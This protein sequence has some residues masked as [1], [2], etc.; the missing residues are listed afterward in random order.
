MS[1]RPAPERAGDVVPDGME[2]AGWPHHGVLGGRIRVGPVVVA[3]ERADA[4]AAE[5]LAA[6]GEGRS[7]G[8]PSPRTRPDLPVRLTLTRSDRASYLP[9][10]P[11]E[12][13]R[14]V[15]WR[16]GT[17]LAMASS[18]AALLV[19]EDARAG[20]VV[21]A[22]QDAPTMARSL[23]NVLRVAVAWRLLLAGRGI[24][25][26]AAGIADH[27]RALALVGPSGAGKSTAARS[28]DPPRS[29]LSDDVLVLESP[30][31][32]SDAWTATESPLWAEP[33]FPRRAAPG[34]SLP[35]AAVARIG[36]A[37]ESA[38]VVMTRAS[39]IASVLAHVPFTRGL[40][41]ILGAAEAV[42]RLARDVPM[43]AVDIAPRGMDW[44]A[45]DAVLS[46]TPL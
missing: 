1:G 45:V 36:Q 14:L 9:V 27:G 34:V 35:L 12:R 15:T 37:A 43:L 2:F 19:S 18:H 3:V 33:A 44:P 23:Q 22:V 20:I 31:D 13:E 25:L 4:T 21:L 26:H 38:S 6:L 24:L 16:E 17:G 40:E 10:R 28:V 11:G 41:E 30:Q 5:A 39:A 7:E 46:G 32:A 29:V 42:A 8:A